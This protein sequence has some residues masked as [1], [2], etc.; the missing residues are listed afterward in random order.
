MSGI[1]SKN[2]II[3]QNW[4]HIEPLINKSQISH[5][6]RQVMDI[7]VL[8]YDRFPIII[9]MENKFVGLRVKCRNDYNNEIAFLEVDNSSSDEA[10]IQLM[11]NS[12]QNLPTVILDGK[13]YHHLKLEFEYISLSQKSYI[14]STNM[15]PSE[16]ILGNFFEKIKNYAWKPW[17][18]CRFSVDGHLQ[19]EFYIT[20]PLGW[21]MASVNCVLASQTLESENYIR[22]NIH[23]SDPVVFRTEE[24][25]KKY[26]YI[27]N[28]ESILEYKSQFKTGDQYKDISTFEIFYKME[29][30]LGSRLFQILPLIFAIMGGILYCDSRISPNASPTIFINY[31]VII[32][33][34][35]YTY[36][37]LESKGY[38]FTLK[39]IMRESIVISLGFGTAGI[40]RSTCFGFLEI[41]PLAA[42]LAY[43]VKRYWQSRKEKKGQDKTILKEKKIPE[44]KERESG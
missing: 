14:M 25:K 8:K 9:T 37:S 2:L 11:L 33:V 20:L 40:L 38:L 4:W 7:Y 29:M 24:Q 39:P 16:G 5:K 30:E 21:N 26:N 3:K 35:F 12:S 41:I 43:M 28:R 27:P 31:I 36:I 6:I 22:K 32:L 42:I 15:I 10:Q 13:T 17:A 18:Y 34:Y 19:P 23:V 44:G 1:N